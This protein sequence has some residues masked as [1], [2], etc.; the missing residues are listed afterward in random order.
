MADSAPLLTERGPGSGT[1]L[2]A[3]LR[4]TSALTLRWRPPQTVPAYSINSLNVRDRRPGSSLKR[5]PNSD[6]GAGSR[7]TLPSGTKGSR[8]SY[9]TSSLRSRF[10]VS[11]RTGA[12]ICSWF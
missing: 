12:S 11:D 9:R 4:V 7:H 10:P 1:N 3:L 2:R 5:C 6:G 8:T